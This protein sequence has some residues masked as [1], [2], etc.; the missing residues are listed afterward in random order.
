MLLPEAHCLVN[1]ALCCRSHSQ[2]KAMRQSV[3]NLNLCIRSLRFDLIDSVLHRLIT[4]NAIIGS[5]ICI[6]W[7]FIRANGKIPCVLC[8][9]DR[10]SGK[11]V[12]SICRWSACSD[13]RCHS[14]S[15]GTSPAFT[16]AVFS[17]GFPLK[18][19]KPVFALSRSAF[20]SSSV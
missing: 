10:W 1:P 13:K 6:S 3:K 11:I 16:T 20:F 19:N 5:D 18:K 8:H 12:S 14:G 17:P 15:G 4:G 9:Y 2:T 7:R